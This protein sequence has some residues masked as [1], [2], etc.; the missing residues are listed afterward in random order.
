[1]SNTVNKIAKLLVD[2][3][4]VAE[5]NEIIDHVKQAQ[6]HVKV[7]NNRNARATMSVG[8]KVKIT[9]RKRGSQQF[10]TILEIKRSKA[11]VDINGERW[12]CPLTI[13]EV[14]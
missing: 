11:I 13:M 8:D 5:I 3:K 4:T 9:S 7:A 2:I 6:R 1:M 12:N 10:G 14:V